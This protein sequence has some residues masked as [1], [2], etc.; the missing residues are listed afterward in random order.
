MQGT[1]L[2]STL[3]PQSKSGTHGNPDIIFFQGVGEE[4][5]RDS[6]AEVINGDILAEPKPLK[7]LNK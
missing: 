7:P 3:A 1:P 6:S 4:V 2:Q 5:R